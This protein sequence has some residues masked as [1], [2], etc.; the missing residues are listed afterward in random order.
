MFLAFKELQ[1]QKSLAFA[2][3]PYYIFVFNILQ[4][5]RAS[6]KKEVKIKTVPEIL[7]CHYFVTEQLK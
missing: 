1:K 3:L 5:S 2:R 6:L 4:Q 7:S